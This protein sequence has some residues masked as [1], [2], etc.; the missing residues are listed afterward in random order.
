MRV[1]PSHS[2]SWHRKARKARSKARKRIRLARVRV[3]PAASRD[4]HL[5]ESQAREKVRA[6]AQG[7]GH[8]STAME[9]QS[10]DEPDP[11]VTQIAGWEDDESPQDD[12]ALREVLARAMQQGQPS[13]GDMHVPKM[14]NAMPSTPKLSRAAPRTPVAKA[15]LPDPKGC[16]RNVQ[17]VGSRLTPFPPPKRAKLQQEALDAPM[18]MEAYAAM[19]PYQQVGMGSASASI[20]GLTSPPL[21]G[22]KTPRL[23]PATV[24]AHH[25]KQIQEKL[26]AKRSQPQD[27]QVPLEGQ[28]STVSNKGPVQ[29]SLAYDDGIPEELEGAGSQDMD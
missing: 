7:T 22:P 2:P 28:S 29:F 3:A 9:I 25:T 11:W 21:G 6:A 8:Q 14:C 10:D 12:M 16:A 1:G 24:L 27:S 13:A 4:L 19:D 23:T 20:P 17:L 15:P 5:L 18:Q 26:D